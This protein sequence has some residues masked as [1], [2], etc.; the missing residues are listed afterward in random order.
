[1]PDGIGSRKEGVSRTYKGC[2]G[3]AP[4]MTCPGGEEYCI[5]VELRQGKRHR[6]K[7]TARRLRRV[8]GIAGQLSPAPVLLRMDGGE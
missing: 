4:L 2:D 7:G 8:P 1:M 5:D 3:Y 6:R